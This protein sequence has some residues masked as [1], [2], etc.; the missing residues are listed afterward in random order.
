MRRLVLGLTFAASLAGSIRVAHAN[1]CN[2]YTPQRWGQIREGCSLT[3]YSLPEVGADMPEITR[4]GLP[5][6]PT[7]VHDQVTLQVTFQHYPSPTD[8]NL[9]PSY[10]DRT[11]ERYTFSWPDL[12]GGDEVIVDGGPY[13]VVV[14]GPGDCGVVDPAFY[15]SDPIQSCDPG[16]DPPDDGTPGDSDEGGGCSA[17]GGGTSWLVILGVVALLSYSRRSRASSRR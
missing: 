17:G 3:T 7:I 4:G 2:L 5:I 1:G 11:F 14:P 8:C 9:I 6:T 15:C 13:T 12:H 10:E 16:M